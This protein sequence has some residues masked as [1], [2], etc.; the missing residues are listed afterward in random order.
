LSFLFFLPVFLLEGGGVAPLKS[1]SIAR[2]SV[3]AID[4]VETE[5]PPIVDGMAL[6]ACWRKAKEIRVKIPAG[7]V[8]LDVSIKACVVD[9]ELYLL[10]RY[11]AGPEKRSQRSWRWDAVRRI[12]VPGDGREES[13]SILFYGKDPGK[14]DVW[15]WRACRTDPVGFAD[16]MFME[17]RELRFDSGRSCWYSEYHGDFAGDTLPRFQ[18]RA[19]SGSASDVKAKGHWD[20]GSLTVEFS[21]KLDTKHA[22]DIPLSKKLRFWILRSKGF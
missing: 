5:V 13:L 2:A 20:K 22:D 18:N 1:P 16:D 15:V 4:A 8:L 11:Q 19:P 17:N 6:D 3:V 14:K 10:V 21:R 9:D 12:Y 7:G